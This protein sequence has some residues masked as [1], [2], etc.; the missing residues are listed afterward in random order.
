MSGISKMRRS[1][2]DSPVLLGVAVF[3]RRDRE[4]RPCPCLMRLRPSRGT[5]PALQKKR[6]GPRSARACPS[7]GTRPMDTLRTYG[8][9][10]VLLLRL[11]R[12]S[13]PL[14]PGGHPENPDNPGHP[15]S[16]TETQQAYAEKV[17][18]TLMSIE[19]HNQE[20]RSVGP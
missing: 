20:K 7:Q 12:H 3:H 8:P 16:D 4:T 11:Y 9:F 6:L 14:G 17:W 2:A 5:A 13:G 19:R 18:K 10:S 15:D 1:V